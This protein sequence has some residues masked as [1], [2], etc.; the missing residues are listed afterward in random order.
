M[1]F[2]RFCLFSLREC[3]I[4]RNLFDEGLDLFTLAGSLC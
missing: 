1:M 4:G 2:F 3:Y